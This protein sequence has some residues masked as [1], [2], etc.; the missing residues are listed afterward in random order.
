MA[1]LHWSLTQFADGTLA[2]GPHDSALRA[3]L[4]LSLYAAKSPIQ[5]LH[6]LVSI[7]SF[8]HPHVLSRYTPSPTQHICLS[9][10]QRCKNGKNSW[11]SSRLTDRSTTSLFKLVV[12]TGCKPTAGRIRPP[13]WEA[14][15]SICGASLRFSETLTMARTCA[16]RAFSKIE[17]K[18]LFVF[19]GKFPS[20][21]WAWQSIMPYSCIVL[22]KAAPRIGKLAC[23]S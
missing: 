16:L 8:S 23:Q 14:S 19:E 15:C 13:D 9:S 22:N 2:A 20:C 1:D 4:S 3:C 7:Q 17:C 5:L 18:L 10:M 6:L 11:K 12:C 21:M